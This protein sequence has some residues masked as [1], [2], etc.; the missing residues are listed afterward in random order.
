MGAEKGFLNKRKK[1]IKIMETD[2]ISDEGSKLTL[3]ELFKIQV[4]SVLDTVLS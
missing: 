1:R 4:Y 2:E 3:E